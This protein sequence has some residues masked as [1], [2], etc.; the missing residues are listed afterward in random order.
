MRKE[1]F[2]HDHRDLVTELTQEVHAPG[3]GSVT[4]TQTF[5][6]R[7]DSQIKTSIWDG[8]PT[9]YGYS[10]GG[11]LERATDWRTGT[12]N[13]TFDYFPA[14]NLAS[15]SLGGGIATADLSY[16]P[17]GAVESLTWLRQGSSV[18]VRE[19]SG[20]SYNV[21][22]LRTAEEVS[23]V[24][25]AGD[26]DGDTG[27]HA[28][29]D[30]DLAGRLVQWQSPFV[31]SDDVAGTDS[32]VTT[33]TLDDGGN[34]TNEEVVANLTPRKSVTSTYVNS[35][36]E[37]R[38][39]ETFGLVA[40]GVDDATTMNLTYSDLG[41]ETH[42][43]LDTTYSDSSPDTTGTVDTS[44]D[45]AGRAKQVD[46][47]GDDAPG[48]VDYLYDASG[49]LIARTANNKT[50]YLFYFGAGGNLAE[51]ARATGST[52][53]RYFNTSG[54]QVLA[55]QRFSDG[56]DGEPDQ[57]DSTWVWLLR[58]P[59]GNVA[60]ELKE[61][62]TDPEV[63]AQR[64]YDPYGEDD[65]GGT[66]QLSGQEA[67]AEK[68][69]SSLGY[70]SSLTDKETGNMLLGPR[71]YD[72]TTDR[73]TS[74]DS[75][76]GSSGDM[77]LGTDPLTGNRY[78]FAAANPVGFYDDGHCPKPAVCGPDHRAPTKTQNSQAGIAER[79]VENWSWGTPTIPRYDTHYYM[80]EKFEFRSFGF[81]EAG[82]LFGVYLG[83]AVIGTLAVPG[84]LSMQA[85]IAGG[86]TIAALQAAQ[87]QAPAMSSAAGQ[88]LASAFNSSGGLTQ[89]VIN[90]SHRIVEGSRLGN[91]LVVKALQNTG[92][93]ISD[94]GKY[95]TSTL[96]GPSG[97][98]Q[99]HFYYNPVE[100]TAYYGRD[101][102]T[103]LIKGR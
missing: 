99:V 25:P 65:K 92:G 16:H 84:E 18:P 5:T 32:P 69:V 13:S 15:E 78:L 88:G 44:Y 60:T 64:A 49:Q 3:K 34:I 52:K 39:A 70:Q 81:R 102:W 4:R 71:I 97:A 43:T 59:K 41:E 67:A 61:A 24:N 50:T 100:K 73:F 91:Q 95:T 103:L 21:G 62:S 6:Y 63:S 96:Q 1:T 2:D 80:G 47:S 26:T 10:E 19:H 31:L 54:G 76:V 72:P 35:R 11:L 27:G 74:A 87:H 90:S 75:F 86:E 83:G 45:P 101:Y 77:A 8:K 36:L 42:R 85:A 79:S 40:P 48:D 9:D 14:G 33:Y 56:G 17:D 30:Y 12:P 22:G 20:I 68:G 93:N 7:E 28:S 58:D 82:I 89:G 51:E 57:N 46:N 38:T 66:S 55:E 23:I 29:F 37:E 94:W 53:V 98:Y